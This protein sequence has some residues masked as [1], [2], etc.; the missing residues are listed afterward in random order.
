[1]PCLSDVLGIFDPWPGIFVDDLLRYLIPASGA[2]LLLFAWRRH[3]WRRRKIQAR[4]PG[5]ADFWREARWSL[6]TV[7]VFSLNGLGIVTY[8]QNDWTLVYFEVADIGGAYWGW[9]Y[10]AVSLAAIVVLH[11]AYFYWAHRLM[12]HPLI[13]RAIH[14]VHHRSQTPSPWAAYA[15][16]P[17]EAVIHAVFLTALI[18]VMPLHPTVIYIFLLHMILRNVIGHSGFEL[19]PRGVVRH[20]VFG[21]LTTTTHHDLHHSTVD[22]NFGLY[23]TWWDRWMETEHGR[24]R[25]TF[26]R[27]TQNRLVGPGQ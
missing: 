22:T 26:D 4:A 10:W 5:R 8:I 1:M 7:L 21:A 12:H 2:F 19:F 27:V 15:F 3:P 11:D 13:F 24:Y 17:A 9:V 14:H 6:V 20:P 25:E 16:A 23:F 18:F